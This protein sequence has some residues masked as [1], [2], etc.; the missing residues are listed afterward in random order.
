MEQSQSDNGAMSDKCLEQGTGNPSYMY[1]KGFKVP[2]LRVEPGNTS[3]LCQVHS[4]GTVNSSELVLS[5]FF[6]SEC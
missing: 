2:D 1:W 6:K 4:G 5:R 3:W